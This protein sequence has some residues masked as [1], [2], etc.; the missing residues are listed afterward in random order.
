MLSCVEILNKTRFSA[1][2]ALQ[3][4]KNE[5]K[6]DQSPC[7][8]TRIK[9]RITLMNESQ[10]IFKL[11]DTLLEPVFVVD[12]NKKVLYCNEPAALICEMSARKISRGQVFDEI[13]CFQ[14]SPSFLSD[15]SLN[16]EA[17]PYQELVFRAATSEKPGRAQLSCQPLEL[18]NSDKKAWL[19]FF[20]DVTL[21]ETLQKKYR[22]ELEQVQHYSKN[23][24]KMV[25]ER[26]AEIKK[27]NQTMAALLDSLGQ[28]FFIFNKDGL[29]L[30]IFSKACETTVETKPPGQFVWDVL[31]LP[32]KQIPGFKKWLTTIFAEMLPFE[33]LS[34]LGPQTFSHSGGNHIQLEY[35]PLKS[36]EGST[37]G[38]VVVATDTTNLVQ[39]R[40][41]AEVERAHAKMIVNLVKN[42][43]QV[44]GFLRESSDILK[45]LKTEIA[46][47]ENLDQENT[48]RHLHTLK[49]GASSFSIKS[50]VDICHE[51]ETCLSQFKWDGVTETGFKKL[52]ELSAT[53]ETS[54]ESFKEENQTILG[55]SAYSNER[56]IETP[57]SRFLDFKKNLESKAPQLA[58]GFTEAFLAEPI[59]RHFAHFNEVL[60]SVALNEGKQIAPILFKN[61]ELPIIPDPFE[62][63]FSTFIHFFRNVVD[64]GIE[65]PADREAL[66][67]NPEGQISVEFQKTRAFKKDCLLVQIKDD[68][69]GVDPQIIRTKFLQKG[70][71]LSQESDIQ[72]V[73]HIFDSQFS[74][75]ETVTETSGRGVGMDAIQFA[76][77]KMG[78]RA[79]IKSRRGR[80]TTLYVLVP[81]PA[82]IGASVKIAA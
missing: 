33:D 69:G 40:R 81:M 78:G 14:D 73:Q 27:L 37:D 51:A 76:T 17:S 31:K 49:G 53:I 38:I 68:G 4:C 41:E 54:F 10:K 25:D 1:K 77:H 13:I 75:K 60:Q 21:E 52:A 79:W 23:L 56:W 67:K 30:E 66:G 28:G 9:P 74:T 50:M 46:K 42:K 64:H 22:A 70:Q 18:E 36:N 48:F 32:E 61:G 24:E 8:T 71:D 47:N 19:I 35:Y 6:P 44:A 58:A 29:C 57:V 3:L 34:P 16:N 43:R 7:G 2:T 72:V 26:T 20:R 59:E 12:E 63:L 80:G 65:H 15:L 45:G 82:S 62:N 11:F 5:A 39:A 55:P